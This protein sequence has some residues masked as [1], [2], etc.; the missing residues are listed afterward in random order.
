MA[1]KEREDTGICKRNYWIALSEEQAL[2]ES[3]DPSQDRLHKKE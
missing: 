2:E 3:M 1:L